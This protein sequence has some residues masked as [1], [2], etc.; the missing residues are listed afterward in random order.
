M[1]VI[2]N[3]WV[4]VV[5]PSAPWEP[6]CSP[7]HSFPF[8]FCLP[9]TWLLWATLWVFLE[10]QRT[11]TLLAHLFH[12]LVF[13]PRLHFFL[14]PLESWF[15]WLLYR[16]ISMRFCEWNVI[17]EKLTVRNELSHF[18]SSTYDVWRI[19][20]CSHFEERRMIIYRCLCSYYFGL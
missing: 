11:L 8:L 17:P 16:T 3:S 6:I 15:P 1:V 14:F 9:R 20:S 18:L 19:G 13:I 4:V 7:C 5:Y 12:A 10:Q 2:M